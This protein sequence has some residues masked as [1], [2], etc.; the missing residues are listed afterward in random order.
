MISSYALQ[1]A[2]SLATFST[3]FKLIVILTNGSDVSRWA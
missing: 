2:N 1:I 3:L